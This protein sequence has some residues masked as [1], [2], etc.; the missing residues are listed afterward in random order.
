LLDV[1]V[2]VHDGTDDVSGEPPTGSRVELRLG[3]VFWLLEPRRLVDR[4]SV[5]V[6]LRVE[7]HDRRAVI[8][9]VL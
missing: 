6:Y 1:E 3:P 8:L 2:R 4:Y 9:L 5:N 7:E